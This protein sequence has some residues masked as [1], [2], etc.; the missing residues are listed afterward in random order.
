MHLS[1]IARSWEFAIDAREIKIPTLSRQNTA[2]QGWGNPLM[3]ALE[4]LSPGRSSRSAC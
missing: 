3:I 1:F 4:T 2:G